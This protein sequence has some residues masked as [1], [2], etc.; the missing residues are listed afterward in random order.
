[1]PG[2]FALSS[3]LLFVLSLQTQAEEQE[4]SIQQRLDQQQAEIEALQS[5]VKSLQGEQD[6]PGMQ[7]SSA[8]TAEDDSRFVLRS[9]R[10]G[11]MALSGGIGRCVLQQPTY[12]N[13]IKNWMTALILVFPPGT[14]TQAQA[15]LWSGDAATANTVKSPQGM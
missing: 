3:A 2:E 9:W 7:T 12:I 13:L 10:N 1:M 4:D 11:E 8:Q 15:W 6:Q 14:T 5:Q